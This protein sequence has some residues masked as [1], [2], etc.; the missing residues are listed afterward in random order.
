MFATAP[1]KRA[2]RVDTLLT[3][4]D[5]HG[6]KQDPHNTFEMVLQWL[7]SQILFKQVFFVEEN[8]ERGV[9]EEL[10]V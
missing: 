1:E 3:S 4:E 8:V 2:L 10:V 9:L 6:N 5:G 7:C